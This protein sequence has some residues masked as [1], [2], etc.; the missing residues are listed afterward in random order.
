MRPHVLWLDEFYDEKY[1]RFRT[2]LEIGDTMDALV[3]IGTTLQTNVPRKLFELAYIKQ[4][5]MI[6][7]NPN[8]IGLTKYGVLELK[9]KSGELLPE[10]V[11]KISFKS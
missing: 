7:I 1:Y 9:G 2:V 11:K 4:L 10:I 8:P 3:L 6:E 5:P